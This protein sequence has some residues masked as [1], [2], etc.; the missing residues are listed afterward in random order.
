MA[1]VKLGFIQ[2]SHR[3]A[4]RRKWSDVLQVKGKSMSREQ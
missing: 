3:K 4:T 2:S 1:G